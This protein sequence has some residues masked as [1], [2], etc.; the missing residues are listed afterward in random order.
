MTPLMRFARF[1][2]THDSCDCRT[3]EPAGFGT[4]RAVATFL[5]GR[6]VTEHTVFIGECPYYFAVG[7]IEVIA[8]TLLLYPPEQVWHCLPLDITA[9]A[10]W[11]HGIPIPALWAMPAHLVCRI[12]G[13]REP[14]L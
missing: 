13:R 12:G 1:L 2:V 3:Q 4:P 8:A 6:D 5:W 7:D 11:Q 10:L 9:R 14:R